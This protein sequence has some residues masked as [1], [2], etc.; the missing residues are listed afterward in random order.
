MCLTIVFTVYSSIFKSTDVT[1]EVYSQVNLTPKQV[2]HN[3]KMA[4]IS[5]NPQA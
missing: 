5:D 4:N 3:H 2:M 1:S